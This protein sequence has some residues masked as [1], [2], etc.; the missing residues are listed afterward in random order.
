[1]KLNVTR[2]PYRL[3]LA[4]V[5][6]LFLLVSVAQS[7]IDFKFVN[8][9]LESGSPR[10]VGA[11]Y[12]YE[13]VKP[14]VDCRVT[15]TAITSGITVTDMDGDSGFDEALQPT[16]SVSPRRNGYLE[17]K[18]QLYIANTW[19]PFIQPLLNVTCIDVDGLKNADGQNH[20]L[21]EFDEINLGGGFVDFDGLGGELSISHTGN[22]FKGK[23]IAGID[24]P[25][26][27][28]S[29]RQVMFTVINVLVSTFT[30]RV[31]VD[32]QSYDTEERL[33]S[34]YF[35]R[36]IYPNF[37][38]ASSPVAIFEGSVAATKNNL[39][40]TLT[41]SASVAQIDLQR[42]FNG[43]DFAP[44]ADYWIDVA[45]ATNARRSFNYSDTKPAGGMAYYRLKITAIGG[46]EQ[47]S[48]I[49]CLKDAPVTGL[50]MKVYPTVTDNSVTVSVNT[51]NEAK[52]VIHVTDLSGRIIKQQAINLKKGMN[53]ATVTGFDDLT[54]GT[55]VVAVKYENNLL[56]NFVMVR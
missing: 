11:V 24:Y 23:N 47:Y 45:E 54:S 55:Y 36:F 22:W 56:S 2:I 35:S 40:W 33:R 28:T 15:I 3:V 5:L 46:K 34:V 39:N 16:L 20:P 50:A 26:R 41:Q 18:F 21:Y 37:P 6:P 9:R 13:D 48:N 10:S 32:N 1:M 14:G 42:S 44:I 31:G 7:Q 53:T 8:G 51:L 43:H 30:V 52:G 38:L 29:A 49:I 17:M 12:L 4:V 27:D 25:G 19:L